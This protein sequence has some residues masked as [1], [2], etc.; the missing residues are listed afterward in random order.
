MRK[1]KHDGRRTGS[2]KNITGTTENRVTTE[3][4]ELKEANTRA[5]ADNIREKDLEQGKAREDD[6]DV[7]E[8]GSEDSSKDKELN[9]RR[10]AHARVDEHGNQQMQ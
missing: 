10:Q 1:N 2:C 3:R 7:A 4:K 5:E 6:T 8:A 9:L